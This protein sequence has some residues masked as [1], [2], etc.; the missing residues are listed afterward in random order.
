VTLT[1]TVWLAEPPGPLQVSVNAVSAVSTPVDA[2]PL[3]DF[4]PPQ[5]PEAT[6]DVAF[7][8][9]HVSVDADPLTTVDGVAP[10]DTDGG[11]GGGGAPTITLTV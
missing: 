4:A 6:H 7:A 11:G 9:L 10:S 5:P 8:E 1:G 3:S 2:L